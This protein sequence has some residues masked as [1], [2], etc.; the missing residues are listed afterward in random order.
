M[1][2]VSDPESEHSPLNVNLTKAISKES[3]EEY[4]VYVN[5]YI[6]I[7]WVFA[8]FLCSFVWFIS[9]WKLTTILHPD[10]LVLSLAPRFSFEITSCLLFPQVSVWN[11]LC[12]GGRRQLKQRLVLLQLTSLKPETWGKYR[13]LQVGR[14]RGKLRS[15]NW[16]SLGVTGNLWGPFELHKNCCQDWHFGQQK[17]FN[18]KLKKEM[19]V[20]QAWN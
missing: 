12:E 17:P 4:N 5:S 10:V 18:Q 3:P 15:Q 7:F 13:K 1:N 16:A 19:R 20:S 6:S 9:L 8:C 2:L 11:H 14:R